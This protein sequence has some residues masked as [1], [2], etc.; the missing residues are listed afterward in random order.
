[1]LCNCCDNP[2]TNEPCRRHPDRILTLICVSRSCM[3]PM[4]PKCIEDHRRLHSN[5]MFDEPKLI[6]LR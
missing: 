1:M 6:D 3:E 5:S 4:C 2:R